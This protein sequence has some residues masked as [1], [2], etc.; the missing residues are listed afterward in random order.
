MTY[1]ELGGD[2]A[3][4]LLE[5]L[6]LELELGLRHDAFSGLDSGLGHLDGGRHAG[7]RRVDLQGGQQRLELA[8]GLHGR[9][10]VLLVLPRLD[11]VLKCKE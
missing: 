6:G 10:V 1:V 7:V 5:G 9:V 3:D 11:E 8:D 4:L 2:L